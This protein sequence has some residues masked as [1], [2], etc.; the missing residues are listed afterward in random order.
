M[1]T[2]RI[3]VHRVTLLLV[4]SLLAAGGSRLQAQTA[5]AAASAAQAPFVPARIAQAIDETQLTALKGN[6][7]PLA[8]PEF[9]QGA[10][11]D[12]TP[13]NRMLLLLRRSPEQEAALQQLMADQM[14]K[15]SPYFHNWLTPAQFGAQFGP[16]DADI[17]TI[18]NWLSSQGFHDIKVGDGK[19]TIEF[20]GNVGL[21]RHAFHTDIHHFLVN[22]ETRQANV[23]DPQIPTA[24]TPVVAGIVSLHNFP[25]RFM[26]R[27]AGAYNGRRDSHGTPQLTTS[28]G[29]GTNQAQ[30]C[31]ALGPAD[32]AAIYD[33][34]AAL[35]G[36]G[37]K[38]AIIGFSNI[39]PQD[40]T[41]FRTV[42]GLPANPPN[43]VL[44]GPDP[45]NSG[46]NGE[47]GE[48][49]LD[50]EWSGAVAPMAQIDFIVS[51]DT[52]TSG[53]LELSSLYVVDNNTDDIMS[54]SFGGCEAGLGG[55]NAFLNALWEQA[56]AQGITVT[57]SSGDPGAAG[58]DDFNTAKT[59]T[60]G[61]AVNGL[62]STPFNIAVGGTDF[63]DIGTQTMFWNSTN[64]A[65]TRQ[66]V[67]GYI[68]ETTWNNSCAAQATSL[69]LNTICAGAAATNI[70]GGAGGVSTIYAKPSWQRG[71]GV[72]A[73][74][75]RDLPDVSLFASNGPQS[76]SFYV[77][78]E[79]DF[80]NSSCVPDNTGA[81]S[82]GGVGGTSASAP[83]FA[84]ILALIE[85]AERTRVPGSSGRQGNANLVLYNIFQTA[86]NSCSSSSRTAPGV[87]PPAGCV[88]N[89]VTKGNNSVPCA[90][91][92]AATSPNCSST[93]AGTN[94]VLVEPSATTT[95][96]WTTT[97]GY[98]LAT[99]LGSVNVANLQTAWAT[100]VGAFTPT[101]TATTVNGGTAQVTITHGQSVTLAAKV[102][103]GSG[104]PT[105]FVSFPVPT[106]VNGGVGDAPL[107]SGAASLPTTF[108]PGGSYN[109]KAH[110]AGDGTF[111]PS[112]D[113]TGVP[114][115][116]NKEASGLLF[117]IVTFDP[118][119][120]NIVSTNATT[121]AY[122]SPYILRMDILNH[123]GN[124]TNCQPL[125]ASGANS[126]CAFDAT[127]AVTITDNG[128]ALT[129]SPFS[130][131]GSGHA[132]DQPIQ[133]TGGSHAL[134]ATY[135]GDI[136]YNAPASPSADTV[137]VTAAATQG[138]L[139]AVPSTGVT[140]ATPV[141]L[142]A[143]IT[144]P[145]S[146]GAGPTGSVAFTANGTAIA[147]SPVITSTPFNAATGAPPTLTSVLTTT[148]TT[149]G[150]ESLMATYTS[151]DTNY[152]GVSASTSVTVTQA[153]VGSFTV[154]STP[155]TLVSS[156]GAQAGSTIT[157]TPAGGFTGNVVVTASN[158]P[159][160]VTCPSSPLT[161]NVPGT[162][163]V[164][165]T[166]NC[167]V[168]ATSTS[169]SAAVFSQNQMFEAKAL[170]PT[171]GGNAKGTGKG[172]WA[173]SAGTGFAAI[174]LLFLPGGRKRL[175]AA[176][177]LGLACLL[178]LSLGCGGGYGGGGGGGGGPVA[179]TTK[180][181]V[182][183]DKVA[184][185]TAFTF[186]V[187]VTGGS[188]A[189]QVQL[190]DNGTMIGTGAAVAGG[191]ATPTAPALAVGTHTISAHY[192]GDAYTQA[193][194]SGTL[195]LTVTG[196]TTVNITTSP[197]A[198]PAASAITVTIN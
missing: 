69:N 133:L 54:L 109:V 28:T 25:K 14:S 97:A 45:G 141:T 27:R 34:P 153:I 53:G 5:P 19:L 115:T 10:V 138:I 157:V 187:A 121:F 136:S 134:S 117:E 181:T 78:C 152:T 108:L 180:M 18:T 102:T 44:N 29:C 127:G 56:A 184:S 129:G 144:S 26:I 60:Q 192:L 124:A 194:Q 195:N 15:G 57:V 52:L 112:D 169:L 61:L 72:P 123:T 179:T 8:R 94:G 13:M 65:G 166:M 193:S 79:A 11:P 107:A 75:F 176:F 167:Q 178:S 47:E 3:L 22:G 93:T 161:I 125:V 171:T 55:E 139:A 143:T 151:G 173:V 1:K 113:P 39:N 168:T 4:A 40:V 183:Q 99:G 118:V 12:A 163:A 116:V 36:A 33:I 87:A 154:A 24:L 197:A 130:I 76:H 132:E 189:G 83:S 86:A 149:A 119:T 80:Q 114:V 88:F 37:S 146:S 23:S 191:T 46:P 6:V 174:F 16:A 35:T 126:G 142:T 31:Y 150:T 111:A 131:N 30:P 21:V 2:T 172:W 110:Y 73:D 98:D 74:K 196:N 43:I 198:T 17:Q 89:D 186:S 177:G 71:T 95:P 135:S 164:T 182:N 96:A 104:T 51:E 85:Q 162:A 147:G 59:A 155:L 64:A 92:P 82:F 50:V 105:G 90:G 128:G 100:A 38:V 156:S 49:D 48:A 170:P 7:H 67:I 122:G 81:F 190:F 160:G 175:H 103:S 32:F 63:D 165:G 106:T 62:A 148:F 84:G 91:G 188:P 101:T 140:T 66:S 20:S 137:T 9:D 58:C 41:A 145:T 120:G 158:L 185:G 68:P 77:V 70:V 42:F 159:P